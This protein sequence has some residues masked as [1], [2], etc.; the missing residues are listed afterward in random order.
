MA[1]FG[2]V[3]FGMARV[4]MVRFGIVLWTAA[5][6]HGINPM[7]TPPAAAAVRGQRSEFNAKSLII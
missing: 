4:G 1:R 2:K 7:N 6:L 3:R 5:A